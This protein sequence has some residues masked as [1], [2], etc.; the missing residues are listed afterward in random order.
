MPEDVFWPKVSPG[1]NL[2][3]NERNGLSNGLRR[4]FSQAYLR[5]QRAIVEEFDL[6]SVIANWN[7]LM[8]KEMPLVIAGPELLGS[9]FN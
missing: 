2:S 6:Y 9:M 7:Q 1:K 3:D 5:R 8:F 4:L